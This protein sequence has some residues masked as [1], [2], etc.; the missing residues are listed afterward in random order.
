MPSPP[1]YAPPPPLSRPRSNPGLQ[2]GG[3]RGAGGWGGAGEAL[4]SQIIG[5]PPPL[6]IPWSGPLPSG[7]RP[8]SLVGPAPFRGAALF[9]WWGRPFRGRPLIYHTFLFLGLWPH[10][11]FALC[12]STVLFGRGQVGACDLEHSFEFVGELYGDVRSLGDGVY[13]DERRSDGL[14]VWPRGLV[15]SVPVAE[16]DDVRLAQA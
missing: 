3:E 4:L 7:G 12:V 16:R 6:G 10:G 9:T 11:L 14:E 8:Y 5:I 13:D 2:A 15:D 1:F